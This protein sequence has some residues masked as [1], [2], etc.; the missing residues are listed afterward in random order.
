MLF[1]NERELINNGKTSDLKKKRTHI[2][3]MLESV[4]ASVDPY[5]AVKNCF[6]E[7]LLRLEDTS[8]QFND[9]DNIHVIGFGKASVGMAQAICDYT[10]I[11]SGAVITNDK[12]AQI[13]SKKMLTFHGGHPLPDKES[14]RG[15]KYIKNIASN[16][17]KK[18][19]L[20]VLISGGG[21]ALLCYPRIGLSDLQQTT[22]LLLA[23]GA[24]IEE[25]N[26]I[27]KHLSFVKGG[28]LIKSTKCPVVSL[29]ISDIVDD[30][31]EFIASGPTAADST[32]FH[33]AKQVFERYKL[34]NE[35]LNS[36]KTII[37]KGINHQLPETPKA[38]NPI[39]QRVHNSIIANNQRACETAKTTAEKLGYHP[40]ILTTSLTGEAKDKGNWLLTKV[41]K[42][43]YQDH[44]VFIMGGETTV[45]LHGSGKGGR[46]Q[47]LILGCLHELAKT[48]GVMA[49]FATDGID[50]ASTAAGAI[51]DNQSLK[52]CKDL[53][54]NPDTYLH[55][56]N[57]NAL[58]DQLH[59][60]FL[61]GPTG[62]NVMD[63]QI[64]IRSIQKE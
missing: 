44:D 46:N 31:I 9:Y 43:S 61:T 24:T 17:E 26:T 1:T 3:R 13:T 14:I 23:S 8:Y 4:I 20:I 16:C 53:H 12:N 30:P 58:F 40:I 28:Q 27:R 57:S 45:T 54:L 11:T 60:L 19:L 33:D 22:K 64:L 32:T 56:N 49:S 34:W 59:D 25:I 63:I 2:L 35:I 18:D 42:P 37:T 6:Q 55:D 52:R 51:A 10:S 7:N 36:V 62:T 50:G 39:F 15:A 21:S 48:K 5:Q 47:E 29:I 41:K 38:N